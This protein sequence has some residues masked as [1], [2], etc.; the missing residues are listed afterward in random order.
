M[1]RFYPP[2]LAIR[3]EA[4]VESRATLR[5]VCDPD[6]ASV[7]L[8]DVVADRKPKPHSVGFRCKERLEHSL[9]SFRRNAAAPVCDRYTHSA[10]LHSRRDEQLAL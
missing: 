8:N 5:I 3:W 4:K 9:H 1:V 2:R 7:R 6:V 10:V